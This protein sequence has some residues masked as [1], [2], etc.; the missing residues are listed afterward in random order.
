MSCREE[1]YDASTL[2]AAPPVAGRTR[3]EIWSRGKEPAEQKGRIDRCAAET[4][5]AHTH[6][7]LNPGEMPEAGE[8]E[9]DGGVHVGAGDVAG[10]VDH[11]GDDEPA[12][13]R[14][15]QLRD[16]LE[17]LAVDGRRAAGHE[18]QQ[19]RRHH[20]RD[21]LPG[22]ARIDRQISRHGRSWGRWPEQQSSSVG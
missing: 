20:L 1:K 15:P 8:G 17:V 4:W 5:Y 19:E 3:N 21:H 7:Y 13:H 12:G 16:A 6:T 18:H 9:R 22:A 2:A 10:G 11:D 14:L